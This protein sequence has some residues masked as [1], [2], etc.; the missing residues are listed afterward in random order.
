MAISYLFDFDG[1]LVDSMPTYV[2]CML[3]ILD[4][5]GISYGDDIVK[6]ITPLGLPGTVRYFIDH[7]GMK[8]PED[9]L[10]HLMEKYLLDAYFHSIPAKP[11]VIPV[12]K[13]LKQ[14]GASLNVLTASP[15][16]TLDACLKRLEMWDLFDNIWS[17]DD[18]HTTKAD[19]EIYVQAAKRMHTTVDQ[20]LFLD[21]NLNAD[22]T[23]KSAGMLTCG[24]YD[25][26]SANYVE[27]M[28]AVNDFYIY[29][30]R[31]LPELKIAQKA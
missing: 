27:E 5:N 26:S 23:A 19:P 29:D 15:H 2:S 10:V 30:F 22:R 1:T 11:Y 6:I 31:E 28:K 4:E 16:I 12:L 20:V 3:R 21:D 13:E 24:V 18:F 17:C 14:Q 8:M 9:E 7:L 25:D